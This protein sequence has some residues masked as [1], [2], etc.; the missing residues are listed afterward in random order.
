M[1]YFYFNKGFWPYARPSII[2]FFL[3]ALYLI[4]L[5][6]VAQAIIVND[7][8][9][10]EELGKLLNEQGLAGYL[11]GTVQRE[12]MY[13]FLISTAMHLAAWSHL[14]FEQ[15]QKWMQI[16]LLMA[17]QILVF[18]LLKK[19]DV[20][21]WLTA[22]AVL[23]LGVTPTLVNSS[24]WTY[25]EIVTYPLIVLLILLCGLAWQRLLGNGRLDVKSCSMAVGLGLCCMVLTLTKSAFELIVPVIL[26]I[27]ILG[28]LAGYLR[29][30][31]KL[32]S[33][34][35]LFVAITG[36]FYYAPVTGYKWLNWK[37]NG[38][39]V[40]T[41][42]GP[43]ALYGYSLRRL[44]PMDARRFTAMLAFIPGPEFCDKVLDHEQCLWWSIYPGD[45]LANDHLRVLEDQGLKQEG[46]RP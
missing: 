32:S 11:K 18:I 13:P 6:L 14:P 33:A 42:R 9:G 1:K 2:V 40:L 39:F 16:I 10:Y 45:K 38:S 17:T 4:Y 15:I 7:S 37:Q 24:L 23:A 44:E 41:N 26:G 8:I 46:D 35:L 36:V 20:R 29:K 3:T 12:P 43:W 27:F 31:K 21:R 5:S 28:G 25:S 30:E 34:F 19:M 22:A